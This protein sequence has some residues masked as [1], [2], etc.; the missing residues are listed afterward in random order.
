MPDVRRANNRDR[1]AVRRVRHRLRTGPFPGSFVSLARADVAGP[2][3]PAQSR[4]AFRG[5]HSGAR[6][7]D[8]WPA[9]RTRHAIWKVTRKI[10]R[11]VAIL[12]PLRCPPMG[13]RR[14]LLELR[15]PNGRGSGGL[16]GPGPEGVIP[17]RTSS[18]SACTSGS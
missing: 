17:W 1:H 12:P 9:N 18:G 11:Q 15:V 3:E 10:T 13:G 5:A 7:R 6:I 14:I 4:P 2:S 16:R 8:G